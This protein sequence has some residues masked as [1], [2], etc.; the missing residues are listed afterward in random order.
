MAK[1]LLAEDDENLGFMIKTF[2]ESENFQITWTKNGKEAFK[3]YLKSSFDLC[4]LDVMMPEEDGFELAKRI[5][6]ANES[7]PII[8]ITAKSLKED[9]IKGFNIGA[10]DYITKPFDED[11][12]VC[13]IKARLKRVNSKPPAEGETL[14]AIGTFSFD[15]NK[16]TLG[17]SSSERRLTDKESRILHYLCSHINRVVRREDLLMAVWGDDDYFNGRSLDVFITKLRKYLK[18]DPQISIENVH[19][20]GFMLIA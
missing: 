5:R 11:E 3:A 13:R 18:S 8:F 6:S 2:L 17:D 7:I 4:L 20:V 16:M 10:D 12:L 9:K 1:I 19:S 14:F 15:V